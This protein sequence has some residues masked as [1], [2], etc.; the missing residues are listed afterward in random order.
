MRSTPRI[1]VGVLGGGSWGT[2]LAHLYAFAGNDV[3]LWVRRG[4][5]ADEINTAHTNTRYLPGYSIH[6]KVRA[7]L[8]MEEV[9]K[10]CEVIV[11]SVPSHSLRETAYELGN[12]VGG[13]Q[14][15]VS[16]TKG[17]EPGTFSRMTDILRQETCC[18]KV[19]SLSGPNLAREIMDGHPAATVI[20]SAYD[21]VIERGAQMLASSVIRVYG[22]RDVVGVELAGALKNILAI[23]SGLATGLGMGDNAKAFMITRGLAEVSRLAVAA[24]A[25]PLSFGGLA[26]VGDVIATCSS[27]LS[28]NHQVGKR[29]GEGEKLG[30]ILKSMVMVAEGVNTTKVAMEY[31]ATLGVELPIT[32]GV[33]Q[34]LFHD[35]HPM[36]VIEKLM[37]RRATY[38]IDGS[39]IQPVRTQNQH[40]SR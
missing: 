24:G 30:D 35:T 27:P 20:A 14:I 7:T 12:Y 3:L 10:A 26:G 39:P 1:S 11:V 5:Q 15:L 40:G 29:L 6:P 38:E 4:E 28:R 23:A 8:D 32:G 25:N 36:D 19:G 33:Y 34:I 13:D 37:V 9:A 18:K 17:L 22:N 31:A 21:E 16:A 2:T